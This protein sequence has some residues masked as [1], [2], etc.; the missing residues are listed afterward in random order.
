MRAKRATSLYYDILFLVIR[1][2]ECILKERFKEDIVD[3]AQRICI[4]CQEVVII[5]AGAA[6]ACTDRILKNVSTFLSVCTKPSVLH[7]RGMQ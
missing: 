3:L 2:K 6:K 4:E 1:R 7:D 5:A